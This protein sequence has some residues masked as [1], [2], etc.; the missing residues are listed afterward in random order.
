MF[1]ADKELRRQ[2][3]LAQKVAA[4]AEITQQARKVRHA[5]NPS[6]KVASLKAW[7]AAH[8][9]ALVAAMRRLGLSKRGLTPD[10]YDS[11]HATQNGRCPICTRPESVLGSHGKVKRLAVDHDSTHPDAEAEDRRRRKAAV[12]GLLCTRCNRG[13]GLF[14]HDPDGLE[15]AAA[16]L[17]TY[18]AR[19]G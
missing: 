12:R 1:L 15:R 3:R 7:R 8:P 10:E 16:Y 14:R 4:Q 17:R 11:L 18:L 6:A 9:E 5:F 13:L 2:Q 19:T